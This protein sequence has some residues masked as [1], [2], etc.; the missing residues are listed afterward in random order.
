MGYYTFLFFIPVVVWILFSKLYFKNEF[1]YKEMI[2]Q[3][4]V[5]LFVIFSIFSFGSYSQT[6]DTKLV[7]GLVTELNQRKENCPMGWNDW[8]DNFCTEYRT[9]TVPDGQTCTTS[10]NGI[11]SCTT[12]YK[13]QYNYIYSWEQ[14]YFVKTDINDGYEI[15]RIDRQGKDIPPR[16]SEI[17]IGDPVTHSIAYTN[18]I[19]GAYDSLFNEKLPSD[20]LP[21]LSYPK[22]RDYYKVN[23]LVVYGVEFSPAVFNEW[24]NQ[25]SAMNSNIRETNANVIIAI[26]GETQEF[27]NRLSQAW[28][29]HNINDVIVSIGINNNQIIWAD[30]RSWSSNELVNV[31]IRDE[32]LNL[33]E[34]DYVKINKII[35]ENIVAHYN[36]KDM[37]EF[38]YLA[39]DI[40]PPTW[41][42]ILAF[43]FLMIA[44]PIITILLSKN[45]IKSK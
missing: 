6:Y 31:S 5:S 18:Y 16:F 41:A 33:N 8:T 26:T 38:E 30:V 28:E 15:S 9:R 27:A 21:P 40:P 29:A 19:R 7:N 42:M 20:V 17:N 37:S 3:S 35:S 32:I 14:R 45:Q 23:R 34:L 12:N 36:Q 10:S 13:T 11:R 1:T 44:S 2:A 4:I 39:D 25:L 22:V 43:I 24:N